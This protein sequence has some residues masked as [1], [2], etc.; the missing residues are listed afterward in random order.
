MNTMDNKTYEVKLKAL[1]TNPEINCE[2]N[3][4]RGKKKVSVLNKSLDVDLDSIFLTDANHIVA[5][6]LTGK[7]SYTGAT[8][9]VRFRSTSKL[10][11]L[12][13]AFRACRQVKSIDVSGIDT[14]N[15]VTMNET[16]FYDSA[17]EEIDL[18]NWDTS[19]VTDF[20]G[21]FSACSNLKAIHGIIDMT[22]MPRSMNNDTIDAFDA[23]FAN[24]TNLRG[25]K[26]KSV[27]D[28]FMENVT[29]RRGSS[30]TTYPG[31]KWCGF[32]SPDQFEIVS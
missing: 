4:M 31:Y 17:L 21:M 23:M 5:K 16:F 12:S 22:S 9:D 19:K 8:F 3:A 29:I 10:T 32:T 11:K 1:K 2:L 20:H 26:L 24:A 30:L 18:S 28:N 27:P 13:A 7:S 14:S 6:I 15:V 25:V